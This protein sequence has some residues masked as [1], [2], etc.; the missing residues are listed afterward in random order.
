MVDERR[1]EHADRIAAVKGTGLL[2]RPRA[3]GLDRLTALASRLLNAPTALVSLVTGDRQVFASQFGLAK[4]WAEAGETP[5]SHSFCQYVVDDDAPLVVSDARTDARLR[6]N[7]AITE[8]G[9]IAYAGIPICVGGQTL[10]SFCAIDGHPRTWSASELEVLRDLAAAVA[11]EIALIRAADEA[12]QNAATIRAILEVSHDAFVSIDATGTVLEWNPAAEALFGYSRRQAVGL[13]IATLIIPESHREQHTEGLARVRATGES[14]LAGQRLQLPAM[15]RAGRSFPIELTLQATHGGRLIFHAFLHDIS[16]R[17]DAEE[18]LRRQAELIDAAPAAIIVRDID[19]TIRSW[20]KGAEQMY[21]W[22]AHAVLGRNINLL[23]DTG[24]PKDLPEVE[25][26]LGATGAWQGEVTHRHTDGRTI[27]SL[28]RHVLRPAADGSG[29]EV[30]ETDTDITEQRRAQEDLAAS[31]RQFR[32]QF[33]QSTI[34]QALTGLDGGFRHVNEAYAAMIGYSPDELYGLSKSAIT[35]PEDRAEDTRLTAGLFAGDSDS[36]ERTKR[37]MHRRGHPV[38]VRVGVRLVRD[39]D[40]RASHLVGI[41]QDITEQL[42]AERERDIALAELT[43]HNE[44]LEG[45][46]L[47][48]LDLMGMLSHDIGTPLSTIIGYGERLAEQDL[49]P[50]AGGALEKIM[51]AAHRID[52]LRHSVLAMCSLD[53][54]VITAQRRPVPLAAALRDALDAADAEVPIDCPEETEVSAN[55]AHLQQIMV[56]FLT[57]AAKYGG[58]ATGITV[59]RTGKRIAVAVHDQGAGIPAGLRAHLFD[60]FT[61]AGDTGAQGHGLGLHIVASLAEANGGTVQHRD[62]DPHGSVFI[63]TLEASR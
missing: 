3:P 40:G 9:V 14:R 2:H 24:F 59:R 57:N 44:R 36:Y 58:G 55:P 25:E 15:D 63:L 48:K 52:R 35:H 6:N 50:A 38:D 60:R 28:S 61:R 27:V 16:E 12:E 19:G 42:R 46:N 49:P 56:N 13:D 51:R 62:N 43:E 32:V 5:L 39:A 37:L 20:N 10:G 7:V 11:S 18:Q 17:R 45:A 53:G 29:P 26:S 41:V 8:I 31:E 22:P 34:G 23:L 21:G 4:R 47:L 33:H 54:G 30:I 1:T